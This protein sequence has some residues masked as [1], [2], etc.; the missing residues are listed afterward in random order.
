MP[1]GIRC[2]GAASR[3]YRN[4]RN[5]NPDKAF[6]PGPVAFVRGAGDLGPSFVHRHRQAGNTR[7]TSPVQDKRVD[8]A[9]GRSVASAIFWSLLLGALI[10][11]IGSL[12]MRTGSSEGILVDIAVGAAGAV[13][14][15]A[16][17]GNASTF[18]SLM[19]GYLGSL[20][21]LALLRLIKKARQT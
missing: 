12:V 10:G 20:G 21:A 5:A 3:A 16:L 7:P 9:L 1:S 13:A 6:L 19:A 18:D 4:S 14:L 17:L 8:S 11:W 15:A 2:A